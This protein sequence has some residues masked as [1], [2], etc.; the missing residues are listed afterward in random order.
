MKLRKNYLV[1]IINKRKN[2]NAQKEKKINIMNKTNKMKIN[3]NIKNNY[4]CKNSKQFV[5][6]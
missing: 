5:I 4:L 6:I 2:I 3:M 1:V